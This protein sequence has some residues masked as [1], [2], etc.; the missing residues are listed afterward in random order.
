MWR[1]SG[2]YM[3][4]LSHAL[5]KLNPVRWSNAC[6]LPEAIAELR[7]FLDTPRGERPVKVQIFGKGDVMYR[8]TSNVAEAVVALEEILAAS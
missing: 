7:Q 6:S 2:R 1:D 5:A 8:K 3:G 4:R